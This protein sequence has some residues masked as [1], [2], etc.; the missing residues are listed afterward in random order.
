[1]TEQE[2]SIDEEFD[3]KFKVAQQELNAAF[4]DAD[5]V[6][7]GYSGI[8]VPFMNLQKARVSSA[9]CVQPQPPRYRPYQ[10]YQPYQ[11]PDDPNDP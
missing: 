8:V 4:A 1:M 2:L 6:M 7:R 11:P 9:P 5:A 10:P 3:R